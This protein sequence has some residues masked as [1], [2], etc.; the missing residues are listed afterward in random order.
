MLTLCSMLLYTYYA[1]NYAGIIGWSLYVIRSG[2]HHRGG[3]ARG[4]PAAVVADFR[5]AWGPQEGSQYKSSWSL[6]LHG[7]CHSRLQVID[8]VCKN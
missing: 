2:P 6:G 8:L 1:Q 7:Q 5:S 3:S 4:D